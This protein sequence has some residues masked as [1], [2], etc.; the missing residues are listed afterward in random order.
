MMPT[1]SEAMCT[2]FNTTVSDATRV[3]QLLAEH[4]SIEPVLEG[5]TYIGFIIQLQNAQF[6]KYLK[7]RQAVS[8]FMR[9][10]EKR[11]KAND[12]T[13]LYIHPASSELDSAGAPRVAFDARGRVIY[14]W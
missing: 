8:A 7:V 1:W 14:N 11:I 9:I 6:E 4:A 3:C 2:L 13:C 12:F 10:I 5:C